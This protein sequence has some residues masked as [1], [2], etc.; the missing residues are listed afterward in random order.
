MKRKNALSHQS[1]AKMKKLSD[2][3]DDYLPSDDTS[4][5]YSVSVTLTDTDSDDA[6]YNEYEFLLKEEFKHR[7]TKE[8][9]RLNTQLTSICE[10]LEDKK[11]TLTKI[12]ES[13][14]TESEKVKA[15]E[16][17]GVL[18]ELDANTLEAIRL[19]DM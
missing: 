15:V 17:F 6:E 10:Q 13:R 4:D 12:L 16:I 1:V 18:R 19:N 7:N 11:I 8:Y 9:R 2:S 14:L 3:S 5:S